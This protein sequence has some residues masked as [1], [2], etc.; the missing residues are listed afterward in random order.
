MNWFLLRGIYTPVS[1]VGDLIVKNQ[2]FGHTLEDVVRPKNAIKVPGRTAI[3]AGRY[4]LRV[5][6]SNKFQRNM[7]LI[8]EVPNFSGIRMHGGNDPDDTD[9]CIL[10]ARNIINS[11]T[12]QGSLEKELTEMLTAKK[13]RHYIEIIDTFPYSGL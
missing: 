5:T 10:V 4:P 2:L 8:E 1:T 9:G 3:P 6:F 11:Q 7:P 13:E 12:I